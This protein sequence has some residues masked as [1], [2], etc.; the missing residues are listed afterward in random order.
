MSTLPMMQPINPNQASGKTLSPMNVSSPNTVLG[1][2]VPTTGVNRNIGMTGPG[3]STA[4]QPFGGAITTLPTS[5]ISPISISSGLSTVGGDNTFVGDFQDTY[6]T[7][8]GTALAG[9]LAG[10]GTS[11]DTAVQATNQSILDAAGRQQANITAEQAA[12]GVSSDSSSAALGNADFAAQV[13][14]TIASTDANMQLSELDTLISSLTKEGTEHG[15][16]SSWTDSI[17]DIFGLVGSAGGAVS[18]AFGIG[19][20]TGSTLDA[21]SML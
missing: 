13:N 2:T 7:G 21:L 16:D 19:G 1:S 15:H 12:H 5:T 4:G 9:V 11:T 14:Q 6:G 8:T 20:K 18:E 17:G 3:A 10:L